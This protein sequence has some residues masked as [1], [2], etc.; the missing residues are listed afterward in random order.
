MEEKKWFAVYTKPRW[1]KKVDGLLLKNSIESWCPVQKVTKQWSDRKKVIEEPLFRSYVFVHIYE[2]DMLSVKKIDGV[3]NFV[4]YLNKP[5]V[6]RNEEIEIIK[7]YL[8]EKD[9]MLSLQSLNGFKE[10]DRVK[11]T[12]GVFMD[13]IGSVVKASKKKVYVKLKSLEQILIVEFSSAHLDPL[14]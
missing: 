11:V 2:K 10:E 7:R 6:I 13:K 14:L 5:A 12:H 4:Y 9:V 3:L 8:G 1:E